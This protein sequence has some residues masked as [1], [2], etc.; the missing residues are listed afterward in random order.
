[1]Y[2]LLL[3]MMFS[4]NNNKKNNDLSDNKSKN[5]INDNLFARTCPKYCRSKDQFW[6]DGFEL[7]CFQFISL[8]EKIPMSPLQ[9]RL[10]PCLSSGTIT[11]T[12]FTFVYYQ[13]S[14]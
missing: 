1:M 7:A 2:F 5:E 9:I 10:N 13:S 14:Y 8:N 12:T 6:S 4:D 3:I 11:I